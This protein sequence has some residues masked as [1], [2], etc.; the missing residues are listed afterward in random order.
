MKPEVPNPP[1]QV[2][3]ATSDDRQE[4]LFLWNEFILRHRFKHNWEEILSHVFNEGNPKV[5]EN[6]AI[7][8]D[9]WQIVA[10]GCL[11][12]MTLQL[13]GIAVE[14]GVLTG[15][16]TRPEYRRQGLLAKINQRLIQLMEE[17]DLSLGLLWGYRDR[18]RPFG[19][20]I[21]GKR[22]RY[23]IPKRKFSVVSSEDISKIREFSLDKDK[24]LIDEIARVQFLS[25]KEV[26]DHHHQLFCRANLRTC[27]YDNP[28]NSALVS[29]NGEKPADAKQLEVFYTAGSFDKVKVLLDHLMSGSS[30][31]ECVVIGRPDLT[32][33]DEA[34]YDF[35]EWFHSEHLCNIRINDLE[36]LLDQLRPALQPVLDQLKCRIHLSMKNRDK[37]QTWLGGPLKAD[38]KF[39]G[40]YTDTQMVRLLF[41]PERPW[42][43]P[44]TD[45]NA[46]LLGSL[47]PLPFYIS[48]F[49]G[50]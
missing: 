46:K 8:R 37:T 25:R 15:I 47:F 2:A 42:E 21:C 11:V 40:H 41:G 4:I 32:E 19:F 30:Y 29:I 9:Q 26:R 39:T 6:C 38:K 5:Y 33:K 31:E 12:P 43:L 10:A 23:F 36:K 24:R 50:V 44:F 48:P 18:Y 14:V 49:E 34:F 35:Y 13:A 7:V 28:G 16:V 17:K 22:N 27:V 1:L 20:E 45:Q 3:M